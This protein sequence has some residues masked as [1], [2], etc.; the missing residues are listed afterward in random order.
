MKPADKRKPR[1]SWE[2]MKLSDVGDVAEVV[3]GGVGKNTLTPQDP[4][5]PKKVQQ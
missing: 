2:P 5:E 1:D 3:Q 4:G